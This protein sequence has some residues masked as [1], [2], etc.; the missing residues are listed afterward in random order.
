RKTGSL[1]ELAS[2][3]CWIVAFL[4]A[5]E[6]RLKLFRFSENFRIRSPA[7]VNR[8]PGFAN[9]EAFFASTHNLQSPPAPPEVRFFFY[10]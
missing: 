10:F 6:P 7:P 9:A 4:P 1:C 8:L 5:N 2:F 3:W